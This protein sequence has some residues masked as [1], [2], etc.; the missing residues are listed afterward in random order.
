M[1]MIEQF[2]MGKNLRF[3]DKTRSTHRAQTSSKALNILLVISVC[4]SA[5]CSSLST[6]S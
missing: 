2:G 6:K 5:G 1:L 4:R 3:I